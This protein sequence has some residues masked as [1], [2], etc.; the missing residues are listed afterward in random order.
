MKSIEVQARI[1][2]Y[3]LTELQRGNKEQVNLLL[4]FSGEISFHALRAAV[5]TLTELGYI[6]HNDQIPDNQGFFCKITKHGIHYHQ[7]IFEPKQEN[8]K[9]EVKSE[10]KSFMD[11]VK[12]IVTFF[13]NVKTIGT[14]VVAVIIMVF[15][16]NI[17]K[18]SHQFPAL[19]S[20]LGI[21]TEQTLEQNHAAPNTQIHTENTTK[22]NTQNTSNHL[23][24]T[25]Q[26]Y[27]LSPEVLK[28]LPRL[29]PEQRKMA[30]EKLRTIPQNEQMEK[31][32]Q[33]IK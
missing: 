15:G 6:E 9:E 4:E 1:L 28:V 17:Q 24:Q 14:V 16:M 29:S 3:L 21:E 33:A 8:K 20:I 12:D 27:P 7:E 19:A 22:Q 25:Q 31:L 10:K 26:L 30:E 5:Y 13:E 32:R 18:I 2:D 11:T 23:P